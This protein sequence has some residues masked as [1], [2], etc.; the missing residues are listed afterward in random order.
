MGKGGGGVE[1]GRMAPCPK[2]GEEVCG[3]E[4]GRGAAVGE[5]EVEKAQESS[6]R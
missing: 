6:A 3:G 4:C 1:V 5:R 2:S